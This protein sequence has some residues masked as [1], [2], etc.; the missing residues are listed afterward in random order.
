VFSEKQ[1]RISGVCR[2][3]RVDFPKIDEKIRGF[4]KK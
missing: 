1:V 4:S 3:K 2:E